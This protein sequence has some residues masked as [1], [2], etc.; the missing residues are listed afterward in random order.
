[1]VRRHHIF[2]EVF[3]TGRRPPRRH[4]RPDS[5]RDQAVPE[6]E[7]GR[8]GYSSG[9]VRIQQQHAGWIHFIARCGTIAQT[10]RSWIAAAG[11]V[12]IVRSGADSRTTVSPQGESAL[13]ARPPVE[14]GGYFVL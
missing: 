13:P 3:R 4:H 10:S 6:A 8:P 1:M 14:F 9:L 5:G 11:D 2:R 12:D 7:R